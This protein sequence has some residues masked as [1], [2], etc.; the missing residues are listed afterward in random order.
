MDPTTTCCPHLACPASG[1]TGQGNLGLHARQDTRFLCRQCRQTCTAT[2]D[3]VFSRRRTAAEL[4]V[5]V[6]T[7]LAPGCPL[8]AS[9][10][11][12]RLAERTV[13]AG[14]ARAG[15]QGQAV[16]ASLVEHPRDLGQGQADA[17][18]VKR[19]GDSVWMALA[20][21]VRTRWWRAGAGRTQRDL[22]LRRRLLERVRRGAAHR[23][24]WGCTDGGC[25]SGRA[26]R[27]TLRDAVSP[28]RPRL[29]PWRHRCMAQVVQRYRPRRLVDVER[30][31]V[32]GTPARVE[33]LRRRSQGHGVIHTAS[34]A[35][36][37]ATCRDRWAALTRR[38]RAL[39]LPRR[40]V[41]ERRGRRS[42][43]HGDSRGTG[44]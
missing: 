4:V 20:M 3:T 12:C 15:Q 38:G 11:A 10:A 28:G 21:M 24:L 9:V 1:Q 44:R 13:A 40:T 8:Q 41:F 22:P 32:D 14:G 23:P 6:V 33:P 27:E 35:R 25:S 26:M 7:W 42:V 29:P 5:T 39:A 19:Q 36:R 17:S 37:N 43:D 30:R 31:L 18:R 34:I 16:Q 2:T